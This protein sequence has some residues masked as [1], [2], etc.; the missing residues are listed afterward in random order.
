MYKSTFVKYKI[1][2]LAGLKNEWV[3]KP[4]S[5]ALF[6]CFDHSE[7]DKAPGSMAGFKDE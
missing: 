3:F 4:I 7:A 1:Y 6:D 2:F 5:A